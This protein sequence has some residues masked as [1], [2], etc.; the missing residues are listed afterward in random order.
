VKRTDNV[1]EMAKK[2]GLTMK[3]SYWT[4]G[5]YDVVAVF[6]APNDEAMTAFSLSVAKLGNVKTQ[7]LRAFSN[8][9]MSAI[10]GKMS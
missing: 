1:R 9:E 6:E 10:L 4:L 8:S 3:E 7:T 5:Q 2:A